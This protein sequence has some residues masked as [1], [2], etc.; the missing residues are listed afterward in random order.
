MLIVYK[1][2]RIKETYHTVFKLAF[3]VATCEREVNF[4]AGSTVRR[5]LW[6]S[7]SLYIGQ[8]SAWCCRRGDLSEDRVVLFELRVLP[9][10][11]H[12]TF[13]L[14]LLLPLF[15]G[16]TALLDVCA[17]DDKAKRDTGAEEAATKEILKLH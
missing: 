15:F 11:G 13:H 16:Q 14:Y 6:R 2:Y 8:A 12:Q 7:I 5:R 10:F 1:K 9:V 3:L 17:S 4:F